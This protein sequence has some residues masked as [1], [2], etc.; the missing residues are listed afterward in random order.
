MVLDVNRE[1]TKFYDLKFLEIDSLR[2]ATQQDLQAF[3]EA[4]QL[5]LRKTNGSENQHFHSLMYHYYVVKSFDKL[6]WKL[7]NETK[8]LD[9]IS[10]QKAFTQFG[11]RKWIAWFNPKIPLQEGPYKFNGLPGL[12]FEIYDSENNFHYLLKQSLNLSKTFDTHDFLE[13]HYGNQPIA[14]SLKQYHKLKLDYYH[15]IVEVIYKFAQKGGS[16]ASDV[17]TH[18][19]EKI[20]RKRNSLQQNIKKSYFPLE[21][22]K[23]IPYPTN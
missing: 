11:G 8:K 18:S 14:I 16:V 19:R 22:D 13:T 4:D 23:A 5:I 10:L 15:N 1:L 17:D 12:I 21:L 6:H 2:K 9:G 3:S 7:E 20:D